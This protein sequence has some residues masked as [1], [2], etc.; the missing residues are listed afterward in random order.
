M[1][2]KTPQTWVEV[3][4]VAILEILWSANSSHRI[5]PGRTHVGQAQNS[6]LKFNV[7]KQMGEAKILV[8]EF[9]AKNF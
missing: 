2:H 6:P 7:G 1:Y 8:R 9:S 3:T 5:P 4:R